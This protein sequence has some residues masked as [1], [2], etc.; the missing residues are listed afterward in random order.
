M[1]DK[2]EHFVTISLTTSSNKNVNVE[3]EVNLQQN[4]VLL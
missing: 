4:F 1:Q 2:T 3:L